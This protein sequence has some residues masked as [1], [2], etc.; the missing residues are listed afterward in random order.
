VKKSIILFV[1]MM[2]SLSTVANEIEFKNL[3]GV[4]GNSEDGGK[5]I[6]GYDQYFSNGSFKSWGEIPMS[7]RKYEVEGSYEVK[8]KFKTNSCLTISKTSAPDIMPIGEHWC[9]EII[10]LNDKVFRF[11]S[12]YGEITTLYRQDL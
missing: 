11:K 3:I 2:S 7:S 1:L 9:D 6:W 8:H 5:T 12:S 10:E 4:W